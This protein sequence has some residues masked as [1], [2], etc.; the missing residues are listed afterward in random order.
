MSK[1]GKSEKTVLGMA[2]YRADQWDQLL[3]VSADADDLEATHEEWLAFAEPKF[4]ELLAHG[5]N[6]EKVAVDVPELVQWCQSNGLDVDGRSRAQFTTHK[7]RL[8]Y[9]EGE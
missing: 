7:V 4:N 1:N 5:V 3:A 8:K 2:W 6:V 9:E